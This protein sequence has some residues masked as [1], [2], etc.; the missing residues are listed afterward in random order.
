MG[1][2]LCREKI[3]VGRKRSSEELHVTIISP[4]LWFSFKVIAI[5]QEQLIRSMALIP[6]LE[7]QTDLLIRW[8]FD[9]VN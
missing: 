3:A 8:F 2:H 6:G 7:R 5:D 9:M 1:S 4:S